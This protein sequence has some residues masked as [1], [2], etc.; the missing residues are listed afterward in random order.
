[1]AL[2][3]RDLQLYRQV[4]AL[5]FGNLDHTVITSQKNRC[6]LHQFSVGRTRSV[7]PSSVLN[8]S[9]LRKVAS[10]DGIKMDVTDDA[11]RSQYWQVRK[12]ELG[13]VVSVIPLSYSELKIDCERAPKDLY[14]IEIKDPH[15]DGFGEED[16][17]EVRNKEIEF[18]TLARTRRLAGQWQRKAHT[19]Y[20]DENNATYQDKPYWGDPVATSQFFDEYMR[21]PAMHAWRTKIPSA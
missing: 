20:S 4:W 14:G 21:S 18:D 10:F 12:Y 9:A 2:I 11:T 17:S 15:V 6:T 1:M 8:T 3:G 16:L 13:D 19:A 7:P 5:T